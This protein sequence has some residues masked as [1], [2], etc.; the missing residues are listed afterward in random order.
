MRLAGKTAYA[1]AVGALAT[2]LSGLAGPAVGG[3]AAVASAAPQAAVIVQPGVQHIGRSSKQPPTTADCEAAFGVA[4]YEPAQIQQAYGLPALYGRGVNG[5]GSTIVIVDSFGS[6]TIANDLTTFDQEFG[7]P[8]PPSFK[9]IQPAGH[10]PAFNSSN[11]QMISWAGETSLDV[12]YAHAVA[13][14]ANILLVETPVAETEG[15]TGF[16]QIIKAEEYVISHHLGNVISQSFSATE[17][18]FPSKASLDELRG[19]YTDAG[20]HHVT[21]LAASGD[22]GAT[23]VGLDGQTYY[24]S[25]VVD[26]PASDPLVTGVGGTRLRLDANGNRLRPDAAWNDT[27]STSAQEFINGDS[28]PSPLATGGGK[29]IFFPRPSYQNSVRKVVGRHRG[30]PD[31]SMSAACSGAVDVYQSFGGEAAGWYP[32]CGTSEATPLFAGVVALAVQVAHHSLGLINPALYQMAARH[33]PGLVDVTSG[34][35]TVQFTQGGRKYTVHGFA[36]GR[37]YDLASGV[38]TVNAAQFVPELA[39]LAG[40]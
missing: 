35:N 17:R 25:P 22:S 5:K 30:V 36:A 27:Y 23:D 10:V 32:T 18:T 28:S 8:A 34:N 4:C 37:G 15:V 20:R 16:P 7:L 19:A 1:I 39:S 24:T 9:I 33:L 14:E 26:W 40:R 21:V 38:G 2:A 13:P 11:T 3:A 29:S 31:I 6:P 12:E